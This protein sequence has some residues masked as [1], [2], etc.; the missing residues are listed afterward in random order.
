MGS[1][2]LDRKVF[3]RWRQRLNDANLRLDFSRNFLKEVQRDSAAG[4]IP[5]P[6][7]HYA[8]RKALR[9][10]RFALAE[11]SKVLRIFTDLV[12][13]GTI[14]DEAEWMKTQQQILP[15]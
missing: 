8:Y 4:G 10:E 7:Q 13:N 15:E 5:V 3:D 11:Y 1:P 14:P 9:A 6:D 12:V 2:S